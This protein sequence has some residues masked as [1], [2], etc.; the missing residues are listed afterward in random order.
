[1]NDCPR[2]C[3][4]CKFSQRFVEED[5]E[6]LAYLEC[7]ESS[8]TV[9]LGWWPQ[10]KEDDYCHKFDYA[11][12]QS[13]GDK[14]FIRHNSWCKPCIRE[15]R[16]GIERGMGTLISCMKNTSAGGYEPLPTPLNKFQIWFRGWLDK[17][18]IVG[19][20]KEAERLEKEYLEYGSDFGSYNE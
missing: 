16:D 12:G 6:T 9:G 19:R 18:N 14:A 3:S 20:R 10:V 7:R 2:K 13:P 15:K 8:P 4:T 5:M 17:P 1:M 11:Y